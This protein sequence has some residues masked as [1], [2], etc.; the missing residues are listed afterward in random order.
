MRD[1][2]GDELQVRAHVAEQLRPHRGDPALGV[3][4]Q[5]HVLDEAAAVDRRHPRLAAGLGPPGGDAQAP[6]Q[7]H[8]EELLGVDVQLGAEP[9]A[10][11]RGDHPHLLFRHAIGDG[12]HHLEDVGDLRGR[13]EREVA[14]VRRRDGD[15]AAGLHGR[16]DEP[17][18]PV[19]LVHDVGRVGKGALDRL[20]VG[21][22]RPGEAAVGAEA[23]VDH[24]P[25]A[26]RILDVD[27]RV[28][29]V[30][31]DH[32]GVDG[33]GGLVPAVGHHHGDDVA[34]VARLV[35]RHG[36]VVGGLH[37]V[38][39][40]PGAR[41][42]VGPCA[43]VAQVGAREDVPHARH[44]GRRAGVDAGDA[45]VGERAADHPH[46]QGAGDH[47]VVDEARLAGDQPAVLLAEHPVADGAG[48][49]R[50]LGGGHAVTP[51]RSRPSAAART[52][53]TMLW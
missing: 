30:V 40:R 20:G 5:L 39:D 31:V 35:E 10:D 25:V 27:H 47:Q 33:V 16:R 26:G 50:L 38:G 34:H 36:P 13:V 9:A 21:R 12:D 43:P 52:A 2:G 24:H 29:R 45:G 7:R 8:G 44:G 6:R 46:P 4:G 51:G 17:L 18:V 11:G 15:D 32:H 14:A 42:R 37:V 53:P 41:H 23:L 49:R 19:A 28:E 48:R 1:A 3:G 22:Q